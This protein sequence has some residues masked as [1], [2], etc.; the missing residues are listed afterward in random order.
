MIPMALTMPRPE[1]I[2][3]AL[4]APAVAMDEAQ[5]RLFYERSAR[6]LRAYLWRCCGDP[7]LADDLLQ[8][9]FLRFLR[10]GFE[11][12]DEGHRRNYLFRIAT[13]L[14]RDH[15]RRRR[16]ETDEVP[17][18]DRASGHD[19]SLQLR[20]DVGGALAELSPTDRQMLWLAYVEGS[21]HREIAAALGLRTASIRSMLFR[22][23]K[24]LAGVLTTRG[25]RPGTEAP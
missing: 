5:F 21:T 11:G 22:A 19:L 6:P 14:V 9:A 13:N 25:L 15:F 4:P 3:E 8:E 18:R 16:P 7:V 17:E 1:A 23:R 24:R 20:S 10:S 12:E 2:R